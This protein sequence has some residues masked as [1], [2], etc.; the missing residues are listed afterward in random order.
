MVKKVLRSLIA[1]YRWFI[2]PVLPPSCR[3]YPSCSEY[4]TVAIDLH[5]PLNGILLAARR[6][7]RCHPLNPGGYDPVPPPTGKTA[8]GPAA[9]GNF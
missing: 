5:G 7:L 8:K 9:R 1:A 6:L 3:F 2:S 4:A